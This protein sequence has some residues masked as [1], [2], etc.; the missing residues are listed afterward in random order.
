MSFDPRN[1]SDSGSSQGSSPRRPSGSQGA[2][3]GGKR[4]EDRPQSE[5]DDRTNWRRGGQ[6]TDPSRIADWIPKGGGRSGTFLG[7]PL[8]LIYAIGISVT[9]SDVLY[10]L[11][12]TWIT[13]VVTPSNIGRPTI[14]TI[15]ARSLCFNPEKSTLA[16]Q[17]G[18]FACCRSSIFETKFS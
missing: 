6:G 2:S 3:R 10:S 1:P 13:P 18:Q 16:I 12:R 5:V 9:Q 17:S 8:A 7:L 4:P 15:D 14:A 11:K